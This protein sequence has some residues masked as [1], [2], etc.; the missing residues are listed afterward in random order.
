M[1]ILSKVL[2]HDSA[3]ACLGELTNKKCLVWLFCSSLR[4]DYRYIGKIMVDVLLPD[5]LGTPTAILKIDSFFSVVSVSVCVDCIPQV[6]VAYVTISS[7]ISSTTVSWSITEIRIL[8]H[9]TM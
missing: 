6:G 5:F 2:Y 3:S 4:N 1:R 9:S 7:M 8:C